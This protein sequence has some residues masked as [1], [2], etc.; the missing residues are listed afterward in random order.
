MIELKKMDQKAVFTLNSLSKIE[1]YTV[2]ERLTI[3]PD[4]DFP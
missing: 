1:F 3:N 2:S 4:I